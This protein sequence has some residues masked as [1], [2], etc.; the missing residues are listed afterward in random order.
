MNETPDKLDTLFECITAGH[1]L[2]GELECLSVVCAMMQEQ[3]N[4]LT[5][6]REIV[7]QEI[8]E[9]QAEAVELQKG[10]GDEPCETIPSLPVQ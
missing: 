7:R 8:A 2:T 4:L 10:G 3:M 9:L 5:N 6:R 1:R